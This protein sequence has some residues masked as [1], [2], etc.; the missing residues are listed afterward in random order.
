M[1]IK[2]REFLSLVGLGGLALGGTG[3]GVLSANPAAAATA[4]KGSRILIRGGYVVTLDPKLGELRGDVAIDN[5]RIVAIGANLPAGSAEIVDA[6]DK[7]VLPGFIDSHR[8][9]WQAAIRHIGVNWTLFQYLNNAFT[10]FGIHFRP[11]DVYAGNLLGRLSALDS[12]I[13]TMLDWSHIMNTPAHAD[14][15][16]QALRDS[17]GRSVFAMGWPQAPDPSRW[18]RGSTADIPGDI[19]RVRMAHFSGDSGLVTMQMAARGPEFAVMDQVGKDL[20]IARDLGLKT[21]M[22]VAGSEGII[23]MHKAGLAGPDITYVHLQNANDEAVKMIKETGGTVSISPLNEEWKTPWRGNPPA[24]VRLL[25]HGLLPSISDTETVVPGDM[26]S[27]M[28]G[29]LG[30]ARYSASNPEAEAP[31]PATPQAW[32]P[33][34]VVSARQVLEMAT[35]AG[36]APL[37]LDA[38][39]GPLAPGRQADLIL[40]RANHLNFFPVNDAIGAIVVAADT[41][42]VDA[43]FVAGKAV[44]FNGTLVNEALVKR[45]RQRAMES[46]DYLFA[47]A[48]IDLPAG[49]RAKKV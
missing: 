23:G 25:K 8:H 49:L 28:R 5:G 2:R 19:K 44:K 33:A 35:I 31:A 14:A 42:S 45:A 39:V 20:K 47:K 17:G 48:G 43:V 40:L 38:Q 36:A 4:P 32:N 29:T 24:T 37:G 12:G 46:R 22:H 16:V 26:F 15:A 10:K 13:T 1:G 21:T 41:G 34:S 30:A 3:A 27:N 7:I 11:E 6:S 18:L 9:T